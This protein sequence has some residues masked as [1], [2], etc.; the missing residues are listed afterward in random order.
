MFSQCNAI[1]MLELES[2]ATHPVEPPTAPKPSTHSVEQRLDA[3]QRSDRSIY[4]LMGMEVWTI[5]KTMDDLYPGFWNQFMANRR[6][7]LKQFLEQK[8]AHRA[9][10]DPPTT[11]ASQN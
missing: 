11:S 6:L 8:Q 4:N 3:L 10:S 5:A 9:P 1:A 7:A 2:T